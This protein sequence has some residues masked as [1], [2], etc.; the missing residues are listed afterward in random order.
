MRPF[1]SPSVT[2]P[3]FV[4]LLLATSIGMCVR[5]VIAARSDGGARA[6]PHYYAEALRFEARQAE[7]AASHA[8]G[9][10]LALDMGDATGGLRAITFTLRDAA[11]AP[12]EMVTGTITIQRPSDAEARAAIP[13]HAAGAG[14]A[15]ALPGMG[16]GLWDV[17]VRARRGE[18][19]FVHTQRVE[20]P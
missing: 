10:A 16:A 11:G 5:A 13:F 15:A 20:V 2:W 7:A 19:G 8:L 4:V 12:V 14:Y 3:L 6:I 18:A 17:T 9:W 1:F